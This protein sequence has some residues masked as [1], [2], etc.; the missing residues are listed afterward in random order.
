MYNL[1]LGQEEQF[2]DIFSL[3]NKFYEE[4]PFASKVA[5]DEDSASAH[6][7]KVLDGGFF[8]LAYEEEKPIGLIGCMV[9][10]FFAN[11]AKNACAEMMWYVDPEHRGTRLALELILTA[12]QLAKDDDCILMSMSALSTSPASVGKFYERLGYV[13]T[14]T[15]FLKEL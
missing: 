14:E 9:Q 12:E 7:F 13:P 4:T 8:V 2:E 10:P 6:I 5:F 11:H 3:C 15:G 1:M